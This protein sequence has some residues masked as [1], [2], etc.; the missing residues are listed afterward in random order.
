MC[1]SGLEELTRPRKSRE[2]EGI[3]GKRYGYR[4][5]EEGV[6]RKGKKG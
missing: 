3:A 4:E 5:G 2:F 6:K 1:Y